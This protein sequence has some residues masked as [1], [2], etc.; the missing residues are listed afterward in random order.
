MSN[1]LPG[2]SLDPK[3]LE[4]LIASTLQALVA[5]VRAYIP[6]G[7]NLPYTLNPLNAKTFNIRPKVENPVYT[8]RSNIGNNQN[9]TSQPDIRA[10][11]LQTPWS[12]NLYQSLGATLSG[13]QSFNGVDPSYKSE[14]IFQVNPSS[15][16]FF[17][18]L[19][20]KGNSPFIWRGSLGFSNSWQDTNV[21]TYA[22]SAGTTLTVKAK[23]LS[24]LARPQST[25]AFSVTTDALTNLPD[26]R[27]LE[28]IHLD[29]VNL[30]VS[31]TAV[32][33]NAA[34]PTS[35]HYPSV[36]NNRDYGVWVVYDR[37]N[38][39]QAIVLSDWSA[40]LTQ[41]SSFVAYFNSGWLG[42]YANYIYIR[43]VGCVHIDSFGLFDVSQTQA[44][45][46]EATT[47]NA[48]P[49]YG[50]LYQQEQSSNPIIKLSTT[51]LDRRIVPAYYYMEQ[52]NELLLSSVCYSGL[53]RHQPNSG[54]DRLAIDYNTLGVTN[55]TLLI[56]IGSCELTDGANSIW[57]SGDIALPSI[58]LDN[59]ELDNDIVA[60][61]T[62]T[63][64]QGYYLWLVANPKSILDTGTPTSGAP[65]NNLRVKLMAS[66]SATW[67]GV[68][69]TWKVAY[70]DFTYK[71]RIGWAPYRNG[72]TSR[73][74]YQM[75][76]GTYEIFSSGT[77][78]AD[79]QSLIASGGSTGGL[80]D[81]IDLDNKVPTDGSNV[82]YC[83]SIWGYLNVYTET[84][85]SNDQYIYLSTRGAGTTAGGAV[86]G[87]YKAGLVVDKTANKVKATTGFSIALKQTYS[88][89][90][91]EVYYA[92]SAAGDAAVTLRAQL[93]GFTLKIG[94][95]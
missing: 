31:S 58:Q 23:R 57:L 46:E 73:V 56:T 90:S 62:K 91:E 77:S 82:P 20:Y 27:N 42:T 30:T 68:S 26:R 51:T 13:N 71:C 61:Y 67:A 2:G 37:I 48:E 66:T 5:K 55:D 36:T 12:L 16:R 64:S 60:P 34:T 40:D 87:A 35:G 63:A 69:S 50:Q 72:A 78:T 53:V 74:I 10:A 75:K 17:G 93:S 88:S 38:N 22:N 59:V 19:P 4:T 76:D 65:N 52:S 33:V 32:F 1:F 44:W 43:C 3:A 95:F 85:S 9:D 6:L 70:P 11:F 80:Y 8:T 14:D 92:A 83:G 47:Q 7:S 41:I 21:R 24:L 28:M 45:G 54:S 79:A 84:S 86:P 81:L 15:D 94:D 18:T 89:G 29:D 49:G 39:R 25:S